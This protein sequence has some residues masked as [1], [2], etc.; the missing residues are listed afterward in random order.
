MTS[1]AIAAA[2]IC[3]TN[4]YSFYSTGFVLSFAA[5]FAITI[6]PSFLALPDFYHQPKYMKR[7]N[8]VVQSLFI[9]SIISLVIFPVL[10]YRFQ[11]VS[12]ITPISNLVISF[13]FTGLMYI[14][15]GICLLS[16]FTFS[17]KV[18]GI[19]NYLF[20]YFNTF[21]EKFASTKG[22]SIIPSEELLYIVIS[23]IFI[24]IFIG[25]FFKK[26]KREKIIKIIVI[27]YLVIILINTIINSYILNKTENITISPNNESVLIVSDGDIYLFCENENSIQTDF[28]YENKYI[29]IKSL[30]L[31]DI[32]DISEAEYKI[33]SFANKC[34]LDYIYTDALIK[35][36]DAEV[37]PIDTLN[38]KLFHISCKDGINFS[39]F[40]KT[41]FMILGNNIDK[42]NNNKEI[43]K[44]ILTDDFF[45][46]KNNMDMGCYR[47]FLD[48]LLRT[49][50]IN[51]R[52]ANIRMKSAKA[53]S[54]T[55]GN[56]ILEYTWEDDDIDGSIYHKQLR[57]LKMRKEQGKWLI[58]D[59]V[60]E[61][62]F[63][64]EFFKDVIN[65]DS[66]C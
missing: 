59:I 26:R 20:E 3:V 48:N 33:S 58:D 31:L 28:I 19:S 50:Y 25:L 27:I 18:F 29:D 63:S 38:N 12:I 23:L 10:Y 51:Q 39:Y 37:K 2:I 8:S 65:S 21:V 13:V 36:E 45:S 42:V 1:L 24:C 53:T 34:K 64:K 56:I 43:D 54:A 46:N 9:S 32:I 47:L 61:G 35:C 66:F 30:V 62:E 22:I 41:N 4:P 6:S 14:A 57:T 7:V 49:T 16:I 44:L 55:S 5:T 40:G 11:T 17:S 52:V 60:I 15:L